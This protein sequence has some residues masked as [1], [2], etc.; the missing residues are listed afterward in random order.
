MKLFFHG[1]PLDIKNTLESSYSLSRYSSSL[2]KPSPIVFHDI[3]IL[4]LFSICTHNTRMV[5][6]KPLKM[7]Q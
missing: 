3:H 1:N 6:C 4:V 5:V 2:C 7:C